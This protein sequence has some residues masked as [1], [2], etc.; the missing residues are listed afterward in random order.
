MTRKILTFA[1][2]ADCAERLARDNHAFDGHGMHSSR[3]SIPPV[4][5]PVLPVRLMVVYQ[6]GL[7]HNDFAV[8][9]PGPDRERTA[10]TMGR[11]SKQIISHILTV[12]K[13]EYPQPK[14]LIHQ[15]FDRYLVRQL[16][17]SSIISQKRAGPFHIQEAPSEPSQ[18][19]ISESAK[20]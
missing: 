4:A 16:K 7:V 11:F 1:V 13:R 12:M 8:L 2:L 17:C 3:L 9:Q 19:F 10:H 14:E 6:V 20:N 18:T 15:I 5:V